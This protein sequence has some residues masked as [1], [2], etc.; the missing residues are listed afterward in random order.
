VTAQ[1][2]LH[3]T[4]AGTSAESG[5]HEDVADTVAALLRDWVRAKAGIGERFRLF[6]EDKRAIDKTL[7][8]LE[9]ALGIMRGDT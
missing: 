1:G 5:F 6:R 7:E 4:A 8:Q 2:K 3:F 9:R